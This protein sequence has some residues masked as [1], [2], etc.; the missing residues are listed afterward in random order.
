MYENDRRAR[1]M[2]EQKAAYNVPQSRRLVR[3][4]EELESLRERV[5]RLEAW[6]AELLQLDTET[7]VMRHE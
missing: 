6:I 3:H 4:E 1:L 2:D 5:S 7:A